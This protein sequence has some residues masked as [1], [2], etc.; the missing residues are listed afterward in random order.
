M[1]SNIHTHFWVHEGSGWVM[2]KKRFGSC[3]AVHIA[4]SFFCVYCRGLPIVCSPLALKEMFVQTTRVIQD[5]HI[6]RTERKTPSL[7]MG[8]SWTE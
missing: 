6:E 1:F 5:A 3:C 7:L 2:K 8:H 4:F